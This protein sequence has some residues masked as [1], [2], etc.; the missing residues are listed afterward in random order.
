MNITPPLIGLLSS[1]L[2]ATIAWSLSLRPKNVA[3]VDIFWPLFLI[4]PVAI[5]FYLNASARGVALAGLLAILVWGL[6][7]SIHLFNRNLGKEEDHRYA[8][9]RSQ[10][11]PRFAFI[12]L[13]KIFWLQAII[14][15]IIAIPL[16][17]I[18][19]SNNSFGIIHIASLALWVIGFFFESIADW[20][21]Y[22]FRK[23]FKDTKKVLDTGLWKYSRHPNYFGEFCM[24][25]GLY[26]LSVPSGGWWTI[27]SPLALTYCLF[28]F[29]G[30][31]RME[32]NIDERRPEYKA[33]SIKT[34][35]FFPGPT[36]SSS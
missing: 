28:K 30:V 7:L 35:A 4:I 19:Q 29:T 12:S 11:G 25:W 15:W 20:Q 31:A 24:I 34:N 5:C 18:M 16:F 32:K 22:V 10:S 17:L 21:L 14:A 1:L 9:I 36:K 3:I 8:E 27:F 6:R 33:Y 23:R 13:F 2:I 26:F